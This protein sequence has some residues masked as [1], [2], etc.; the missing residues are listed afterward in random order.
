MKNLLIHWIKSS[1]LHKIFFV[2]H[3]LI[4]GTVIPSS[5]VAD[6]PLQ[7]FVGG[8][9]YSVVGEPIHFYL[10]IQGGMLPYHVRWKFGDGGTSSERFP[11]HVYEEVDTFVVTVKVTDGEGTSKTKYTNVHIYEELVAYANGPYEGVKGESI[12][13]SGEATGGTEPYSWHWEF[14]DGN[15]SNVQNATH[16]YTELGQY[17]VNLTVT[18]CNTVTDFDTSMAIIILPNRPPEKPNTPIGPSS[19]KAGE[20]YLYSTS[21]TDPDG[22]Q[23]CYLF[24]WG[25]GNNSGWIGPFDGG[26]TSSSLHT[27][28]E[29]GEYVIKAKAKDISGA[30]S[31]WATLEISMPKS[32][33]FDSQMIFY[34]FIENYP[35]LFPL[36]RQLFGLQ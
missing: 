36:L 34:R 11:T 26:E 4:I 7:I 2:V 15:I 32:R 3:L 24:D 25:D 17:V 13:F 21:T 10:D 22:D 1:T 35:H 31:D 5:I 23:V 8:P 27:W 20:E 29:K 12:E 14:G 33:V 16:L 28:G 19:G 30:E 9:Y 6:N 18:D